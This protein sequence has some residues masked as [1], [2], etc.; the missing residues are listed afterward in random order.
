MANKDRKS[1]SAGV[2]EL[3]GVDSG[4]KFTKTRNT[5]SSASRKTT[6]PISREKEKSALRKLTVDVP[7]NVLN[8][9]EEIYLQ[10]CTEYLKQNRRKLKRVEYAPLVLKYGLNRKR[11]SEALAS[12]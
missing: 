1:I 9:Y 6:K 8:E 10:V 3:M 7:E 12:A 2:T 4:A 5:E 11:I